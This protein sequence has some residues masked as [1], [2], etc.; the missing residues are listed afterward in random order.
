M[1]TINMETKRT[2]A[3]HSIGRQLNFAAGAGTAVCN[4]ILE[5]HGLSLSQWAVLSSLWRNGPLG[6]KDI[7]KLTGNAPPA[8]SRIV[9][10]MIAAGLLERN[11]VKKDRRSVEIGLSA[12]G[13]AL[14]PLQHVFEEVN[15]VLLSDFTPDETAV[16]F[17]LLARAEAN[18]RR[19]LN[20]AD[21]REA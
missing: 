4:R 15:A 13:E 1:A 18:G 6:I 11:P 12:N 5:P 19:W 3:P 17:A 9:D 8:V 14:R 20:S 2:T 10:R 16:L 21:G 7:A